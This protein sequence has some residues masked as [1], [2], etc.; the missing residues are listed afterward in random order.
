MPNFTELLSIRPILRTP[1]FTDNFHFS[2]SILSLKL[3]LYFYFLL[4]KNLCFNKKAPKKF[5]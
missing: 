5:W 1:G 2:F 3:L 4:K